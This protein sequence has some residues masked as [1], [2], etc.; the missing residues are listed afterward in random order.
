MRFAFFRPVAEVAQSK[1]VAAILGVLLEQRGATYECSAVTA[2]CGFFLDRH[3]TEKF[4]K[5]RP[6]VSDQATEK[7]PEKAIEWIMEFGAAVNDETAVG[8][9]VRHLIGNF[10]TRTTSPATAGFVIRR[11]RGRQQGQRRVSAQAGHPSKR[12]GQY[13]GSCA[14]GLT[15]NAGTNTFGE[16]LWRRGGHPNQHSRSSPF[17]SS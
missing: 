5:G 1:H 17:L 15:K 10:T 12:G 3:N 6:V 9:S 13:A 4:A 16:A 11:H 7:T 14:L 8:A 2:E